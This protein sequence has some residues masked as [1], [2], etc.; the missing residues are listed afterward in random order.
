MTFK[1]QNQ[2]EYNILSML[3]SNRWMLP[4]TN[5]QMQILIN[6]CMILN[7]INLDCSNSAISKSKVINKNIHEFTSSLDIHIIEKTIR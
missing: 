3:N 1:N 7:M 4:V 6:L 2:K 5:M